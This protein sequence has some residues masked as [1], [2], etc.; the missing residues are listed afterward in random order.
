MVDDGAD[1]INAK[2]EYGQVVKSAQRLIKRFG[3]VI[4]IVTTSI[5]PATQGWKPGNPTPTTVITDGVF[6]QY[7]Q[8]FIDGTVVQQGDQKVLFSAVGLTLPPQVSGHIMRGAE[9]WSIRSLKPLNPGGT[10][11]IYVAQVRQ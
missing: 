1:M 3:S 11:I 5:A 6:V 2:Y 7:E 10:I 4:S 8:K 9:K